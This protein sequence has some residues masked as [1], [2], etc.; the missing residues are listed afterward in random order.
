MFDLT[1]SNTVPQVNKL[2]VTI[3]GEGRFAFRLR[4]V[5][6]IKTTLLDSKVRKKISVRRQCYYYRR[7]NTAVNYRIPYI[8]L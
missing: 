8:P 1:L 6:Q 7:I 2:A 3:I 4:F 5:K